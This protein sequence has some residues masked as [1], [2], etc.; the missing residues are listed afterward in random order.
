MAPLRSAYWRGRAWASA[1]RGNGRTSPGA[2]WW[3]MTPT[4]RL[5]DPARSPAAGVAADASSLRALE[6]GAVVEML[7]ARAAF[8]PSRELAEAAA[9]VADARHV[10][11]MQEQTDEA[12]RLLDEQ[13]QATIGGA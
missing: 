6:F 10:A 5:A 11:L 9:P 3:P 2:S 7:A 8:A 13:A 1:T 4:S 12:V